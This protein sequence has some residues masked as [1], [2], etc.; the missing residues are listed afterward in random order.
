MKQILILITITLCF[1]CNKKEQGF[2]DGHQKRADS[3]LIELNKAKNSYTKLKEKTETAKKLDY[4]NEDFNN[5]FYSFMTDSIFQK[6]RVKFPFEYQTTDIDSM[7]ELVINVKE[8][9]W[10]YN[11]FYINNASERTQIYDNFSLKFQP[12]NQRL[13]HWYG[14]ESG[15]DSRYYFKGFKGKWFLIKKWDSG[16]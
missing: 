5:F 12:S 4:Q 9:E 15:G 14:I 2:L 16:V 6:S 10:E 7:E 8:T 11:S 1:S 3:L 13:L